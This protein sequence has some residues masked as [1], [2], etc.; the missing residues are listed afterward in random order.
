MIRVRIFDK[1]QEKEFSKYFINEYSAMKFIRKLRYSTKLQVI[2]EF[3]Y[4]TK[5]HW[6][7]KRISN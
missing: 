1:T 7:I 6:Y 2:G 5:G 3:E 4:V